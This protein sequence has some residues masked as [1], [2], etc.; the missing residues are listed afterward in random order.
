[1]WEY[2]TNATEKNLSTEDGSYLHG[3]KIFR[4][5]CKSGIS[6]RSSQETDIGQRAK[7]V[8]SS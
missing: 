2:L 8:K 7:T 3:H 4:I 1:M 6:L 5:L